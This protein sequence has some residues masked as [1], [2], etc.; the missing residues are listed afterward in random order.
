MYLRR[1]NSIAHEANMLQAHRTF[2]LHHR[3]QR[4]VHGAFHSLPYSSFALMLYA[5]FAVLLSVAQCP[6]T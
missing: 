6:Y 3:L 2:R 1:P 4:D 5:Q